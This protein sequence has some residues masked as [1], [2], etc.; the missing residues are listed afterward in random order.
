MLHGGVVGG[1]YTQPLK[2][3]LGEFFA[4]YWADIAYLA[5]F[6]GCFWVE[7]RNVV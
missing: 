7:L 5:T 1:Q 4:P 6:S 2:S 3:K